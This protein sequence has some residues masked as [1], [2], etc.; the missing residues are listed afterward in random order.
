MAIFSAATFSKA[1][2]VSAPT[3]MSAWV[4]SMANWA[5]A[6]DV[7]RLFWTSPPI[8]TVLTFAVRAVNCAC[9][10]ARAAFSWMVLASRS[11]VPLS[12]HQ[13]GSVPAVIVSVT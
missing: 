9:A 10:L 6:I 8:L 4:L 13:E 12:L 2:E 3:W 11:T 7:A 1:P 5:A